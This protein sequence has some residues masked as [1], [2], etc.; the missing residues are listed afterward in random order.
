MPIVCLGPQIGTQY[1]RNEA[2][3]A[4]FEPDVAKH[5]TCTFTTSIVVEYSSQIEQFL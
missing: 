1:D 5:I 3:R 4:D 2:Q